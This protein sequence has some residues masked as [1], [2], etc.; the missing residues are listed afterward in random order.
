MIYTVTCSPAIDY[1]I[2]LDALAQGEINRSKRETYHFGGKGINVS[3]MLGRLGVKNTAMGFV[4]GFTGKALE[5][6]L[7]KAGMDTDFVHLEEGITRINIKIKTEQE[8]E[9]N[10]Q[11]AP[12]SREKLNELFDK[13]DALKE[14]DVLVVSGST[15]NT[16]P[17][18]TYETMLA[19][20]DGRGIRLIIDAPGPILKKLLKY[21]PFAIKP[22]KRELEELMGSKIRTDK[23]LAESAGVLQKMGAQNVLISLGADGAYLL[24]EEGIS[25][26]MEASKVEVVNTVGAGDSMVAGFLAGYLKTRD[27]R[28][29]LRL[30]L[31]AGSATACSEGLADPED[32]EK[33]L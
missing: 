7:W 3:T 4:G 20:L 25:Y 30:G 11:G 21:R 23:A 10:T 2:Y 33:F 8:T 14:G 22:N 15:P 24:S 19:R 12:I 16:M 13:L 32:I 17:E 5:E 28:F 9:I 26:R 18:E 27:Y 31:A 29:A 1:M 6:G